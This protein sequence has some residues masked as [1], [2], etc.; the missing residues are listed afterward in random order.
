MFDVLLLNKKGGSSS[1]ILRVIGDESKSKRQTE[2]GT[3]SVNR[4]SENKKKPSTFC[5]DTAGGPATASG[6]Y[7]YIL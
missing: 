1:I 4:S 2:T 7:I 6:L 3:D 5:P